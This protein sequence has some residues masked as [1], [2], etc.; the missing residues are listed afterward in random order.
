TPTDSGFSSFAVSGDQAFTLVTRG[1]KET[2]VALDMRSGK[3]QWS[4]S[5]ADAKY[6]GGGD[7]GSRENKGGDGP[8][9][10]PA[11]DDGKVYVI[12][13]TLVVF[14][15]DAKD[16]KEIWKYDVTA[17]A[18][19]ENIRWESAQSPVI[20]GSVLLLAGGGRGKALMGLDKATGA[21]K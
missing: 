3:E 7:S 8:R 20:D 2:L 15:F 13:G 18:G 9:S 1:G 16:G 12:D 5:L 14:C 4:K 10:T 6:E 21:V 17:S 19:G 11:I